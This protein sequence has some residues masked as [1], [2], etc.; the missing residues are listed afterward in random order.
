M[1]NVFV[2]VFK[3]DAVT[4]WAAIFRREA[5]GR[6]GGRG[7]LSGGW[8]GV[9]GEGRFWC[10]GARSFLDMQKGHPNRSH[11]SNRWRIVGDL[12]ERLPARPR[13]RSH[14]L[15]KKVEC[16]NPPAQKNAKVESLDRFEIAVVVRG[17]GA[18]KQVG[19]R[20][21]SGTHQSFS[22]D[23]LFNAG[24]ACPKSNGDFVQA[25]V[26]DA[27]VHWLVQPLTVAATCCSL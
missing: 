20:L 24:H 18:G 26:L 22:R 21:G 9:G 13:G 25:H 23:R 12:P 6:G 17:K 10:K 5:L 27:H 2:D 4:W 14:E 1:R 15:V 16:K 3:S 8:R 11:A 19:M 7:W